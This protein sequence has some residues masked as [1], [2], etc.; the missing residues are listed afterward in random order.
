LS[1]FYGLVHY[2][3]SVDFNYKVL[4]NYN[5][6]PLVNNSTVSSI[7]INLGSS[8]SLTAKASGGTAPYKYKYFYKPAGNTSY[9][10]LTN[11]TTSATYTHK[12]DKVMKYSYAVK[13]ADAK[14]KTSTKY[15]TV[16]VNTPPLTNKSTISEIVIVKGDVVKLT[17]K[18]SGGKAP[19][20]YRYYCKPAG[21]SKYKH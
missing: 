21:S 19:Y 14:G 1:T 8:V 7:S 5:L 13:I 11:T 9:T 20:K 18:A 15:F 2:K 16:T 17:A 12:P 6:T 10:A 3:G 4:C